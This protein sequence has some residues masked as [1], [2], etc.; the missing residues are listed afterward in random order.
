MPGNRSS[1]L[2]T[3]AAR[4]A[5]LA[6]RATLPKDVAVD[7]DRVV[8]LPDPV[9]LTNDD[10][11]E[12]LSALP[13]PVECRARDEGR[14]LVVE[15]RPVSEEF[16]FMHEGNVRSLDSP[17]GLARAA[18]DALRENGGE[19]LLIRGRDG[20]ELRASLEDLS[21]FT[22]EYVLLATH[23]EI[24]REPNPHQAELGAAL[25]VE[26]MHSVSRSHTLPL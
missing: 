10:A 3:S 23:L 17:E 14:V 21:D 2:R 6:I 20:E 22:R 5:L 25:I 18:A 12:R 4:V 15:C 19:F 11:A 16:R 7:P 9:E 13:K 24:G 1:S 26:F 8:L